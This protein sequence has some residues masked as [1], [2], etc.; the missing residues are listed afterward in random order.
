MAE[1]T[2]GNRRKTHIHKNIKTECA[3]VNEFSCGERQKG[4]RD[5]D[6]TVE[7]LQ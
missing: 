5:K 3:I 2:T 7:N 1:V 4:K 6:K